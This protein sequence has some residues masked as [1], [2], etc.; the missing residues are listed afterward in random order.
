VADADRLGITLAEAVANTP[1]LASLVSADERALL[2]KPETY[3]GMA[4]T[5]RRRLIAESSGSETRKD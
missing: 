1:A 2:E 5:F 4:E 3:L